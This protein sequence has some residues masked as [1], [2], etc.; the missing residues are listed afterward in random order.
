M[1]KVT[2]ATRVP[3]RKR[4]ST[5]SEGKGKQKA[6][7]VDLAFSAMKL[8]KVSDGGSEKEKSVMADLLTTDKGVLPEPASILNW[9]RN[10]FFIPQVTFPDICNCLVEKTNKYSSKNQQSFKSLRGY[11]LFKGGHVID[12]TVHK[13]PCRLH[14]IL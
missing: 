6:E 10:L 7:L 13:L 9:S 5:S 8:P 11:R 3:S 12:L 4:N 1:P 2:S 14:L